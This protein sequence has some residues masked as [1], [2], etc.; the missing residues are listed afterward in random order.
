M[1]MGLDEYPIVQR[2][3]RQCAATAYQPPPSYQGFGPVQ[4]VYGTRDME[5]PPLKRSRTTQSS[6]VL[7]SQPLSA[8]LMM[9]SLSTPFAGAA[10]IPRMSTLAVP[11]QYSQ[12]AVGAGYAAEHWGQTTKPPNAFTTVYSDAENLSTA[13]T[14][15][16]QPDLCSSAPCESNLDGIGMEPGQYLLARGYQDVRPLSSWA[17]A[18]PLAST[19]QNCSPPAGT[20]HFSSITSN[21]AVPS[22]CGSLVEDSTVRTDESRR[23]SDVFNDGASPLS[24]DMVHADSQNSFAVE[25]VNCQDNATVPAL[26]NSYG[27]ANSAIKQ[28]Y[29]TRGGIVGGGES[30]Y[31]APTPFLYAQGAADG[32]ESVPAM[33]R[34]ESANAFSS[35]NE[36]DA[37]SET[38]RSPCNVSTYSQQSSA[39]MER[40]FSSTSA[41]SNVSLKDRARISLRRHVDNANK[42]LLQ[43]QVKVSSSI[44]NLDRGAVQESEIPS[45]VS[46]V[47]AIRD[48]VKDGKIEI[49]KARR[50]RPKNPKLFCDLCNACP[51][52]FRG[53]HELT[54]HKS[55]KH[56]ASSRK[57]ICRDPRDANLKASVE[58]VVPLSDCKHCHDGKAYGAYYNAAAHLRRA[59]FK[60]KAPR[61]GS[62]CAL[63]ADSAS[64]A[65]KPSEWPP[66]SELKNWMVEVSGPL[67]P[68]D[69]VVKED[70]DADEADDGDYGA[71]K[72]C[73]SAVANG[74]FSGEPAPSD[75]TMHANPYFGVG[76]AFSNYPDAIQNLP[77]SWPVIQTDQSG[78]SMTT[79]HSCDAVSSTQLFEMQASHFLFSGPG[80]LYSGSIG[81]PSGTTI[82]QGTARQQD[83]HLINA[84]FSDPS[85]SVTENEPFE[86]DGYLSFPASINN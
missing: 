69:S 67:G 33:E 79:G 65:D 36:L 61:K 11:R 10:P 42:I 46:G 47:P 38:Q 13:P 55:A 53:Q 63:P 14:L 83:E 28:Y 8:S 3:R 66:M 44:G 6:R 70:D 52:G 57:W 18:S 86:P 82:T 2:N 32:H 40:S 4:S 62:N 68:A 56:S 74:A 73:P 60:K 21:S 54:R 7:A 23:F 22:S 45:S 5:P 39:D 9:P 31:A 41:R 17:A 77:V 16:Y 64:D 58:A 84:N 76:S 75:E 35:F 78:S 50:E 20:F 15:P 25:Y 30:T 71:A 43:P 1:E 80:G 81:S 29:A 26:D 27:D 12:Q 48:A 19:E 34:S 49:T 37:V 51:Y 72:Y 59:H 85:Q 24:F